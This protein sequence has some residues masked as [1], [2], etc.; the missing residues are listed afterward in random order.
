M[1]FLYL[2]PAAL[3]LAAA[4][5]FSDE[6]ILKDGK[7]LFGEVRREGE[8]LVVRDFQGQ[9]VVLG[10]EVKEVMTLEILRG[11]HRSLLEKL[12]PNPNQFDLGCW[13]WK[14]GL[15][16]DARVHFAKILETDPENAGARWSLGHVKVRGTWIRSGEWT[17]LP[18]KKEEWVRFFPEG[19][20]KGR[21]QVHV[22]DVPNDGLILLRK[23]VEGDAAQR[24]EAEAAWAALPEEQRREGLLLAIRDRDDR[25]RR[26]AAER[27][28][29]AKGL[30]AAKALAV[31]ALGD[32]VG[33]VRAESLKTLKEGG[34]PEACDLV[35]EGLTSER[36]PVRLCALDA[37]AAFPSREAVHALLATAESSSPCL[38]RVNIFIGTHTAYVR[39]FDVEVAQMMEIGDPVV[40]TVMEGIVLDVRVIRLEERIIQTQ[41]S[42]AWRSLSRIAGKDLGRDVAVW[43]KWAEDT[44][45]KTEAKGQG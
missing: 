41:R 34:F 42:A 28:R 30:D 36:T 26:L 25:V 17:R 45:G 37:L 29:G 9:S 38:P 43:R 16:D 18:G 27:L 14:R 7:H 21:L 8:N 44:Y 15:F 35:L 32:P 10:D 40:S 13:C 1:R 39:D 11:E 12:G 2:I 3:A 5:A 24:K 6:I 22:G 19:G 4:P 20:G 33:E 31:S 23:A